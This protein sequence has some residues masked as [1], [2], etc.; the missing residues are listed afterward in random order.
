V[1]LYLH[2]ANTPSSRGAQLKNRDTQ[3][4]PKMSCTLNI[5]HK[6]V[7]L[8]H[9]SSAVDLATVYTDV[10]IAFNVPDDIFFRTNVF[11]LMPLE[12]SHV[13]QPRQDGFFY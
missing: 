13:C 9:S 2:S 5:L 10:E 11:V 4:P 3:P 12:G 7:N 6:I 8:Q 1:E